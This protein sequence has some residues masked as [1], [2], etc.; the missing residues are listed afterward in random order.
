VAP[1]N[2]ELILQNLGKL[3]ISVYPNKEKSKL[4]KSEPLLG[5]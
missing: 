4:K 1:V 3:G 2:L 5:I